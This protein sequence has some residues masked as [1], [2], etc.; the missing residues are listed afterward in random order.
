MALSEKNNSKAYLVGGGISSLAAAVYLINDGDFRGE[1]IKIFEQSKKIGGSLDSQDLS[2][3]DGY[4]MRGV[5]MF[6]EKAFTCVFD[7]MSQIPSLTMPGKTIREEFVDFNQKNR[8]YSKS[9]LLKNGKAIDAR[10]L[11]LKLKDRFKIFSLLLK[12]ESSLNDLEIQDHFTPAFFKSNFWYEFCTVFAFQPWHSLIEF[13]RYFIRFIQSFPNIDTV[14]GIEIAPYNQYEFLVLPIVDWLEE[15]GVEFVLGTEVVNLDFDSD[16]GEEK[17]SKIYFKKGEMVGR[18]LVEEDDYVFVTL[19]SIVTNSSFGSMTR[20]PILNYDK[21]KSPAWTF[22]ENISKNRPEFGKPS[23]FNSDVN[24]SKWTSFTITFRDSIFFELIGKFI[25]KKVTTYGGLNLVDS[26][27]FMSIVL[28]YKPYFINQP[29]EINLCWG[30]G[31][32]PD[33]EG[34]FVKKKMTECTGEEILTELIYHLGFEEYL[35]EILKSAICIPCMTPYVTS[36]FLPRRAGDRPLVIPVGYANLAFLG[37]Y[38]EIPKDVVFTVEYAVRS[39]QTAVFGLLGLKKETVP[40]YNG[41]LNIRV[42]LSALRTLFR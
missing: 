29:K 19:G 28:T 31:L 14:E 36:H 15:H 21:D 18:V 4:V 17:V 39:A 9:R 27:W 7:L 22:W 41:F 23:V 8:S 26:N 10:P 6:E 38:C 3:G 24:K 1:N 5:R 40:I 30:M 32:S 2:S 33:K 12:R 16:K 25:N 35:E 34:N 11:G 13:R 42:L 37:Q 20:V